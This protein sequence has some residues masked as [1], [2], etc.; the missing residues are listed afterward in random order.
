MSIIKSSK[1]KELK[2]RVEQLA[3]IEKILERK[4]GKGDGE[5][6]EEENVKRRREEIVVREKDIQETIQVM[7]LIT[8]V[9]EN[10]PEHLY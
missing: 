7:T 3:K 8:N 10:S 1:K 6:T 5:D 4:R 9:K 2:G